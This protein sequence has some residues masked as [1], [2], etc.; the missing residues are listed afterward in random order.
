[1]RKKRMMSNKPQPVL[2]VGT[3]ITV[4]TTFFGGMSTIS[5]LSDNTTWALV[6]AIGMLA[7]AALNQGLAYYVRSEVVPVGDTIMYLD[8]DRNVVPGP[9]GRNDEE[10]VT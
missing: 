9:A 1:M 6:G 2:I 7:T 4:L 10:P 3:I 5:L 8:E